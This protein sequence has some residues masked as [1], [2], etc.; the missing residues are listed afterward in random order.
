MKDLF[1]RKITAHISKKARYQVIWEDYKCYVS[2]LKTFRTEEKAKTFM[3]RLILN[4]SIETPP[5]GG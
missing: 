2:V 3:V 1:I 5:R 4:L